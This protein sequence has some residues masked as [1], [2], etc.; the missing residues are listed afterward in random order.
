MPV[1]T[2][3]RHK[4]ALA[5]H[6]LLGSVAVFVQV[7]EG[8]VQKRLTAA[9]V[10]RLR[11]SHERLLAA[12]SGDA[13]TVGELAERLEITKQAVS[14][15]VDALVKANLVARR[16]TDDDARFRRVVLTD[17]GSAALHAHQK[18]RKEATAVLRQRFGVGGYTELVELIDDAA[19]SLARSRN[20]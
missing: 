17:K 5:E 3:T 14:E 20:R 7:I 13:P 1:T 10:R 19:A 2:G 9:K 18:A 12:I 6:D 8:F 15:A 16:A 4:A 11:P